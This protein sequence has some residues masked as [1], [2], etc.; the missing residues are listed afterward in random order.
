[1]RWEGEAC[2]S[3]FCLLE[4]SVLM[5]NSLYKILVVCVPVVFVSEILLLLYSPFLKVDGKKD[6]NGAEAYVS[7]VVRA[8]RAFMSNRIA[9]E[10][11]LLG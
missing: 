4:L 3:A 8:A 6:V 7:C 10:A 9:R 11:I 2:C 5:M 1:M